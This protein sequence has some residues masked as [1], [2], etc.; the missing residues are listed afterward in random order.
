MI[1][2]ELGRL[3]QENNKLQAQAIAQKK[4]IDQQQELI[5]SL[6]EYRRELELRIESL[7][8]QTHALQVQVDKNR[9]NASPPLSLKRP[10]LARASL[11]F[12]SPPVTVVLILLV[13]LLLGG[14]IGVYAYASVHLQRQKSPSHG[15]S[16]PISLSKIAPVNATNPATATP[17]TVPSGPNLLTIPGLFT[18]SGLNSSPFF[19]SSDSFCNG[20]ALATDRLTYSQAE[21]QEMYNYFSKSGTFNLPPP[22]TLTVVHGGATTNTTGLA[23]QGITLPQIQGCPT[24]WEL[25]NIGQKPI[26]LAQVR[27]KLL[28]NATAAA[29]QYRLV[30]FCSVLARFE[31]VGSCPGLG[32][33]GQPISYTFRFGPGNAGSVIQGQSAVG[34]SIIN[35][36][37]TLFLELGFAP[38]T[39][40]VALTYTI[41]PEFVI[42]T[43][44]ENGKVID[45][46]QWKETFVMAPAN[47]FGCYELQGSTFVSATSVSQKGTGGAF[48]S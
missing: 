22:K 17:T 19:W 38:A 5:T 13:L 9:Q 42:N 18:I 6:K 45:L 14:S 28:A 10:V 39:P 36:G 2:D 41:E 24:G 34:E 23:S 32:G 20:P 31:P 27:M 33:E 16:T 11:R 15:P 1:E 47:H 40:S 43:S 35:P 3:Q 48:C 12:S 25:T 4:L 30:D 37:E 21:L 7:A 29:A 8:G 44:N 26:Q 46:S